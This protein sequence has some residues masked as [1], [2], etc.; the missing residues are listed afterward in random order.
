MRRLIILAFLATATATGPATAAVVNFATE[1][2]AST[3]ATYVDKGVNFGRFIIEV[4]G[5]EGRLDPSITSAVLDL[6]VRF[7]AGSTP[8]FVTAGY[9]QLSAI[10]FGL[11]DPSVRFEALVPLSETLGIWSTNFAVELLD[12]ALGNGFAI[13]LRPAN[14]SGDEVVLFGDATFKNVATL[15]LTSAPDHDLPPVPLPAAGWLLLAGIGGL[16]AL[17]RRHQSR[18]T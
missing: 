14:S 13:L 10:A 3:S 16:V 2:E 12:L 6:D 5:V 11:T 17:R 18:A 7:D 9:A 15:S 4:Q 8:G 1:N